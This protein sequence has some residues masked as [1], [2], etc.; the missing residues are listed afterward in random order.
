MALKGEVVDGDRRAGTAA[1]PG[2][3]K[4]GGRKR[5]LPVVR[6]H[7]VRLKARDCA[8]PD[9]GADPRERGEALRIVRPVAGR[10]GRD[11]D[12]RAASIEMRSVEREQIETRRLAGEHAR[13][14]SEQIVVLVR[15]R[16]VGELGLDR[17]IS[18]DERPHFDAFALERAGQRPSDVGEPAGLDQ[19]KDLRGDGENLQLA[20]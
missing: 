10:P 6:V 8:A 15:R 14:S 2:I 17:R 19:R 5:R 12:C 3:M 7:D 9:V 18:R 20:H 13:R 11:R 1:R 16:G 4:I